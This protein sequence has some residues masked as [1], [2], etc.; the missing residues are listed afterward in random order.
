VRQCAAASEILFSLAE[1]AIANAC[2][3][4]YAPYVSR[5]ATVQRSGSASLNATR[6]ARTP[7]PYQVASV[8]KAVEL[9][10]C[11]SIDAPEWSLSDLA[12]HVQVPKSTAHNLLRTLQRFDLLRQDPETRHYRVGPRALE[13]GLLFAKR[14][15]VL[16]Q[17]RPVLRRLVEVTGETCKLGMLSS[18]Q[19]VI[20]AA[21][22]SAFQLHTR[23]DI[24]TRWDLHSTSLGKTIL[25]ALTD[26]EAHE[27]LGRTGMRRYTKQTI[28]TW[29]E[30]QKE[31]KAVRERG[32]ALDLE[33]NEPGVRCVAAAVADPLR[34]SVAAVSVSGPRVRLIDERMQEIAREVMA[35]ARSISAPAPAEKT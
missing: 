9:L 24:G 26:A 31:L 16:T 20:V 14:S 32:Y 35:A 25:A 6:G 10:V 18:D 28:H 29:T 4:R 1:P 33:E 5:A 3:F 13:L 34:G 21:L 19:V 23:G 2:V 30:M 27:I 12:R 8:G 15:G 7:D 11:F 22:E 17:A